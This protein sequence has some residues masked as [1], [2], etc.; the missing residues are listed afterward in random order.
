MLRFNI[1]G[2]I[3][4]TPSQVAIKIWGKPGVSALNGDVKFKKNKIIISF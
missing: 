4:A 3:V 2:F 1:S